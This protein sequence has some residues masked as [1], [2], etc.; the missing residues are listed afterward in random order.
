MTGSGLS[1]SEQSRPVPTELPVLSSQIAVG[2]MFLLPPVDLSLNREVDCGFFAAAV[3]LGTRSRVD[4]THHLRS[5]KEESIEESALT[6]RLFNT[7]QTKIRC[8][9]EVSLQRTATGRQQEDAA[10]CGG[11]CC[12]N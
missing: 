8:S 2:A 6:R 7:I 12:R 11:N 3:D 5:R 4:S 1:S 9:L 10:H